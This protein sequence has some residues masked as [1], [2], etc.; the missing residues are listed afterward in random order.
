MVDDIDAAH[1]DYLEEG[2][3]A[4]GA[5]VCPLVVSTVGSH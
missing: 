4:S 3:S 1:R 2:L 5:R